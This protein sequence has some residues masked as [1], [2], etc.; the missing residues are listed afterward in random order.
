MVNSKVSQGLLRYK[1][2]VEEWAGYKALDQEGIGKQIELEPGQE[3]I[4]VF[5]PELGSKLTDAKEF[6]LKTYEKLS[7][8]KS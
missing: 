1:H 8:L 7:T 5:V 2:V 3:S 6:Q 4:V